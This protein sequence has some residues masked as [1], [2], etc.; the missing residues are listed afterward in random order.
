M[1]ISPD[2]SD[3]SGDVSMKEDPIIDIDMMEDPAI[4]CSDYTQ[5]IF[6]YLQDAEVDNYRHCIIITTKCYELRYALDQMQTT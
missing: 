6:S 4:A 3:S 2:S 5:D 1:V